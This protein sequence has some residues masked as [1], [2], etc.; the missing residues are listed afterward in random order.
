MEIQMDYFID[1]TSFIQRLETAIARGGTPQ[2][3]QEVKDIA[4][5]KERCFLQLH[6]GDERAIANQLI[7]A[8]RS[9]AK[10]SVYH[11]DTVTA[12]KLAIHCTLRGGAHTDCLEDIVSHMDA[13][14][15]AAPLAGAKIA[16]FIAET[17]PPTHSLQ[18]RMRAA[19][20]TYA[21]SIVAADPAAAVSYLIFTTYGLKEGSAE[22]QQGIAA[23]LQHAPAI[24]K[25]SPALIFEGLILTAASTKNVSLQERVR[26]MALECAD[27]AA[28]HHLSNTIWAEEGF[29]RDVAGTPLE[30]QV[31]TKWS[32]HL[33]TLSTQNPIAAFSKAFNRTSDESPIQRAAAIEKM[34]KYTSAAYE[35]QH[36]DVSAALRA[37]RV[38]A[39][40]AGEGSALQKYRELPAQHLEPLTSTDKMML[41]IQGAIQPPHL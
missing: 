41:S 13:L 6:P 29:A 4:N 20:I 1:S 16:R 24:A 35:T 17:A 3:A 21:D 33:D 38:A 23:L 32:Q 5:L 25:A 26:L 39:H 34:I 30:P 37:F 9:L 22:Q 7:A 31:V 18:H 19:I 15:V 8:G 12:F 14:F 36:M 28:K 27:A 11:E 2:L 10:E 40:L